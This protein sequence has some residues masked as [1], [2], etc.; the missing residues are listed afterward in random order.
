MKSYEDN[1]GYT[2]YYDTSV[3]PSGQT[4]RI[5]F[6]EDWS[7]SKYFY[8]I[9][10]VTSHK[11][12][13]ADFIYGQQTGKDGLKG[14]LWA[15]DKI[16]EFEEYIKQKYSDIPIIIYCCWTDNRRRNVYERGLRKLG[17]KYN[18]IFGSKALSKTIL[19]NK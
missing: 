11:R 8:N 3:L 16:I 6:Q 10:L 9:Y 17:Y 18:F 7:K 2:N 12:K 15:K 13:Q 19:I 1:E 14:L 5:E 4:I